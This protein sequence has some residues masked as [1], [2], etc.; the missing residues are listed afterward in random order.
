MEITFDP[1]KNATNIAKRG[2]DFATLTLDF[3]ANATVL[4]AKE[5]RFNAIGEFEGK[6]IFGDLQ[7]VR[8]RGPVG[9][10]HASCKQEGKGNP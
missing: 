4:N 5:G 9:D 2:Y 8:Y 10:F 6:I 1:H 7:A 3:F